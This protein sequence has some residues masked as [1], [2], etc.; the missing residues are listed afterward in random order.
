MTLAVCVSLRIMAMPATL[1]FIL[2]QA[3]SITTVDR[4]PARF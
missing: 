1:S 3:P 2:W 4:I